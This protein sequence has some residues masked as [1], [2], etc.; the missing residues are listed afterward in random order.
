MHTYDTDKAL[1]AN[2]YGITG[3]TFTGWATSAEGEKEYDD[4]Q[5]VSNIT[6][7]NGGSVTLYAVWVANTYTITYNPNRPATASG[8]VSGLTS[9]SAHT[10]DIE[11]ALTVNEYTLTGWT[12]TGWATTSSGTQAYDDS[13][14]VKNLTATSGGTVTLYAVWT[15]NT[16]TVTYNSNKPA[17]ASGTV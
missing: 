16:Y 2:G 6:A 12:F 17:T 14:S 5:S 13:Q 3:W 8:A 4:K 9:S 10:Y 11:K 15:A 7:A 1:T